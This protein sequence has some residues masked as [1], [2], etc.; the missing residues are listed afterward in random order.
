MKV[1]DDTFNAI[2]FGF[3]KQ[4]ARAQ[5][6]N[7]FASD[8]PIR[9]NS[10]IKSISPKIT[11]KGEDLGE[12]DG[13]SINLNLICYNSKHSEEKIRF[14]I[15]HEVGHI[16]LGHN[17]GNRIINFYSKDPNEQLANVFAAELLSPLS[18]LKKE[19]LFL[20]SLS[21]LAQKYWV[22]KDMMMWRLKDTKL[23]IKLGDWH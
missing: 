10:I 5:V 14:T 18:L 9:L 3:V 13:Y 1:I 20:T 4:L 6:K 23:D 8:P 22:S 17:S 12:A 7:V 16:L 2:T 21:K 19:S 15:A 11:I